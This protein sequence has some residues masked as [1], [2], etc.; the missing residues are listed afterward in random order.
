MFQRLD[1]KLDEFLALGVPWNDCVVYHKGKCVYRRTKG[2]LDLEGKTPVTGRELF[3]LYS[4]SKII[5]CTAAL[6]LYE[7][8]LFRLI[9]PISDY[10]PEY[11]DM[12]V[13]G[14]DGSLKKA[15]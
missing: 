8:G 4:T 1:E 3:N 7:K 14:V 5:T 10:L 2:T 6:M 15:E 9:D 12:Q 13:K 11:A